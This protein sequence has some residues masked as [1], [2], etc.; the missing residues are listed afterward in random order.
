MHSAVPSVSPSRG[1]LVRDLVKDVAVVILCVAVLTGAAFCQ[2]PLKTPVLALPTTLQLALV[3][4]LGALVGHFRGYL[5]V[6][7]YLLLAMIDIRVFAYMPGLVQLAVFV[8]WWSGIAI[9][10]L[11]ATYVSGRVFEIRFSASAGRIIRTLIMADL[12]M[13]VPH[14]I[15]Q[16]S[17]VNEASIFVLLQMAVGVLMQIAF[18]Y[19]MKW[20]FWRPRVVGRASA[21]DAP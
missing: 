14:F 5:L 21:G 10:Y 17:R 8:F 9:G 2:I 13:I 4:V 7:I 12:V 19:F 18:V 16:W 11:C 20:T 3:P 15:W 6:V 1:L